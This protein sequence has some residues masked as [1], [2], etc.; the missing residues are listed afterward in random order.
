MDMVIPSRFPL[1]E[2][3]AESII[4]KRNK[5]CQQTEVD[6]IFFPF[7]FPLPSSPSAMAAFRGLIK[8]FGWCR[9]WFYSSLKSCPTSHCH[10]G[11]KM[12]PVVQSTAQ[13]FSRHWFSPHPVRRDTLHVMWHVTVAHVLYEH[14]VTS[15]GCSEFLSAR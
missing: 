15:G 10:G 4:Y 9:L 14:L 13:G 8:S 3:L 11:K 12:R 6:F 2:T 5:G 7:H 1:W